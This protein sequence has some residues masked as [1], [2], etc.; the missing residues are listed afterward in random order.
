MPI[1]GDPLSDL[2][3][4]KEQNQPIEYHTSLLADSTVC[5]NC[6]GNS[7][8]QVEEKMSR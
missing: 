5:L 7:R 4:M 1:D 6:A 8:K 2:A 3:V